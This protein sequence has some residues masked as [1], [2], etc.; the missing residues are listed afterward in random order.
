M[1]K[2]IYD[3]H[4]DSTLAHTAKLLIEWQ[5]NLLKGRARPNDVRIAGSKL[6]EMDMEDCCPD[7]SPMVY[8]AGDYRQTIENI[9]YALN[10]I[11]LLDNKEFF[12][13]VIDKYKG[14]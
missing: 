9:N 4:T 5:A 6:K 1:S 11:F 8:D 12:N 13:E 7:S 3:R 2:S 10:S 14:E